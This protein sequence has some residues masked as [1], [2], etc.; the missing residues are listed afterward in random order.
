MH[1]HFP[2][3]LVAWSVT[4]IMSSLA[5]SSP[6]RTL[7]FRPRVDCV[8]GNIIWETALG[9]ADAVER[10]TREHPECVHTKSLLNGRAALSNLTFSWVSDRERKLKAIFRAAPDLYDE[11]DFGVTVVAQIVEACLVSCFPADS[12]RII[13]AMLPMTKIIDELDLAPVT[14]IMLGMQQGDLGNALVNSPVWHQVNTLDGTGSAPIHWACR[15]GNVVALKQ[16]ISFSANVDQ[17][18]AY[19]SLPLGQACRAPEPFDCIKV[20]LEA[21]AD[22]YRPNYYGSPTYTHICFFGGSVAAH[23]LFDRFPEI[24]S[25]TDSN[26]DF[27]LH[28]LAQQDRVPVDHEQVICTVLRA[29]TD[30]NQRNKSGMTPLIVATANNNPEICVALLQNEADVTLVNTTG[31]SCF[32]YATFNG[33]ETTMRVLEQALNDKVDVLD[34]NDDYFLERMDMLYDSR[35]LPPET[36]DPIY[37][38]LRNACARRIMPRSRMHHIG[39]TEKPSCSDAEAARRE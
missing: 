11:D 2:K 15:L 23:A 39:E 28:E 33:E 25:A 4:A 31:L 7:R 3:W 35:P 13:S 37:R 36:L 9:S 24:S 34:T 17:P 30:V 20:L 22:P 5:D 21:G 16:L 27:V 18:S 26:G 10:L 38:S 29:G 19:G 32:H 6:S 14:K 12:L 1:Y 8:A